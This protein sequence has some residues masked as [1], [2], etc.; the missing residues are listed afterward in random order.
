MTYTSDSPAEADK[1]TQ[2]VKTTAECD[3]REVFDLP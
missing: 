1:I 2:S 3:T